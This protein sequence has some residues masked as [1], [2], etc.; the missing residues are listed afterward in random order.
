[1]LS[2]FQVSCFCKS[3]TTLAVPKIIGQF[4]QELS[5]VPLKLR[6]RLLLFTPDFGSVNSFDSTWANLD[7]DLWVVSWQGWSS[8][9]DMIE[10]VTRKVLSL[11]DGVSTVWYGHS[12]GALVAYEVLKRFET[13]FQ[14]LEPEGIVMI[15]LC[16]R[17]LYNCHILD[18]FV[19]DVIV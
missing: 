19:Q 13:R 5:C 7:S 12:M 6:R 18:L 17:S 16:T 15:S 3:W 14:S 10:Q 1:M 11:A 4:C 9:D 2:L 8:W